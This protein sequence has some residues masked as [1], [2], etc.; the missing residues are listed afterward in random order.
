VKVAELIQLLSEQDDDLD[1]KL[2]VYGCGTTSYVELTTDA[3]H[4]VRPKYK[5]DPPP[6]LKIDAVYN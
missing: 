2:E 6:F 4:V 3:F 1:V 5:K